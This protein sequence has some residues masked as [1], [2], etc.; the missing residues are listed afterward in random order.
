M[1]KIERESTDLDDG[2]LID[3]YDFGLKYL[4]HSKNEYDQL[5]V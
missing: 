4:E 5:F 1:N 3:K 2:N